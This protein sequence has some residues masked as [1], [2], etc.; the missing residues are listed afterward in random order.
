MRDVLA[1]DEGTP[2]EWIAVGIEDENGY[3]ESVAYCHPDNAPAIAAVPKLVECLKEIAN[4]VA[5]VLQAKAVPA[6]MR[7]GMEAIE[8]SVRSALR[9]A[10]VKP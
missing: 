4:S 5:L 1:V 9:E 6:S 8:E 2:R 10:G 3:A 7:G